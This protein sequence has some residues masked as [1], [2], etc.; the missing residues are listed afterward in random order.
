MVLYGLLA[1]SRNKKHRPEHRFVLRFERI[2]SDYMHFVLCS[3]ITALED[4]MA[5]WPM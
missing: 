5:I 1:W 3:S 4:G 2:H